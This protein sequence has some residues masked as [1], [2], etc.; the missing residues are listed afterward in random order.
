[1]NDQMLTKFIDIS[2]MHLNQSI[3]YLSL[4]E[5]KLEIKREKDSKAFLDYLQTINNVYENLEVY[6][7]TK[8]R[9]MLIVFDDLIADMEAK[10][11]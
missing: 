9:K 11:R 5:K 3:N 7:S 2:N 4:V 10:K 8:K 1:M 6:N